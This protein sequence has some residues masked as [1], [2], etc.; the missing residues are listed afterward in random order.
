M[1]VDGAYG[2]GKAGTVFNPL[3][4]FQ[5][6]PVILRLLNILFSIIVFGS[7][8][9]Q[10]YHLLDGKEVCLYNSD[11]NA[12]SYGVGIGVIAFLAGSLL[13]AGEYLFP[14]M[15]SVKTRRHFVMG[16]FGFSAFWS[17]LYGVGFIY[18]ASEWSKTPS[19][20]ET[21]AAGSNLQA[22]IAF[23]FFSAFTWA[24]SAF[25]AYQRYRQGADSAFA[26]AYETGLAGQ[27]GV[28]SPG[29]AGGYTSFPGVGTGTEQVGGG[30]GGYQGPPFSSAE[31]PGT[32]GD[33]QPP[34]Y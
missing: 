27:G 7:I 32:M 21:A 2:A 28:T 29:S 10:G 19:S 13:L 12:C 22:A 34:T 11:G 8:S 24:G 18:L 4:F 31:R 14:Q 1:D 3:E 30:V 20:V 16:D 23:S 33:Y 26:T 6:P 25:F 17:F 9:S 15:S 5:R